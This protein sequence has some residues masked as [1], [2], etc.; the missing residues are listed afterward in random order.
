MAIKRLC[1]VALWQQQTSTVT[2]CKV[3]NNKGSIVVNIDVVVTVWSKMKGTVSIKQVIYV[4]S[5][6]AKTCIS[7]V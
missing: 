1:W 7:I 6:L 2:V 3:L 5:P 4:K